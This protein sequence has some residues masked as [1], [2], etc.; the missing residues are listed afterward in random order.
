MT[1]ENTYLSNKIVSCDFNNFIIG[2][3]LFS[4]FIYGIYIPLIYR[5]G[6]V[7]E[8]S[9]SDS[10][11]KSVKNKELIIV[12]GVPG[13]GKKLYVLNKEKYTND[14]FVLLNSRD[15]FVDDN[16]DFN[17]DGTKLA[18]SESYI[19]D[20]FLSAINKNID[21]I[22]VIGFFDKIHSYNN[23]IK[24]GKMYNYKVKIIEIDCCD[25]EYLNL[26]NTRT[27]F[28]TPIKKSILCYNNW[29]HDDRAIIQQAYIPDF[30]GDSLPNKN[31][32]KEQLDLE[33]EEYLSIN[34]DNI[35]SLCYE[36]DDEAED[37]SLEMKISNS[38]NDNSSNDNSSNDN[39]SNEN[40]DESN[41]S[42]DIDLYDNEKIKYSNY[43]IEYL[44]DFEIIDILQRRIENQEFC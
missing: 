5:L 2:L 31:I 33:L 22:Y 17:F 44:S 28:N 20:N 11:Y 19:L 13:S 23:Y 34:R 26:F 29:E 32:T 40:L 41:E 30:E 9:L 25:K 36:A 10:I 3:S 6:C 4:F 12:R 24:I 21:K 39:S 35:S 15:F 37:S 7:F 43:I 1:G 27:N 14:E 16:G 8:K 42:N 38:S 18:E